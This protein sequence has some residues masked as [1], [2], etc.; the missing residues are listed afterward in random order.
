MPVLHLGTHRLDVWIGTIHGEDI[1]Y[2]GKPGAT[3]TDSVMISDSNT[4]HALSNLC[5]WSPVGQRRI[6][7]PLAAMHATLAVLAAIFAWDP[8]AESF[9]KRHEERVRQMGGRGIPVTFAVIRIPEEHLRAPS[10]GP[11]D[12][13][14]PD[15][16]VH[17]RVIEA[18]RIAIIGNEALRQF[19]LATISEYELPMTA[20]ADGVLCLVPSQ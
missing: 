10:H 18:E 3:K 16:V 9:A 5:P 7:T 17:A 11:N 13:T 15:T 1:A 12:P 8:E 6:V 2:I 20:H 19:A 4:I 14:V